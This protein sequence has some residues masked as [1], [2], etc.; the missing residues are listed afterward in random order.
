MITNINY[1]YFPEIFGDIVTKA[2]AAIQANSNL[3]KL[4]GLNLQYEYGTLFELTKAIDIKN[5]IDAAKYP[6]VWLVWERPENMK[7]FK[8][9][10]SNKSYNV[11]P[12]VYIAHYTDP[13]YSSRERYT[14]VFQPVLHPIYNELIH[15]L[16]IHRNFTGKRPI[17]HNQF[18]HFFWGMQADGGKVSNVLSNFL[19]SIELKIF[20]LEISKQ[21]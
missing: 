5:A 17:E 8:G 20:N 11:S 10:Y 14:E 4:Q 21:C 1:Q 2:N 16:T 19:D 13:N 7:Q 6:L 9:A 12:L 3:T 15:Q 18:E